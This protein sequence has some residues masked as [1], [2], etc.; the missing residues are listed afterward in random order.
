MGKLITDLMINNKEVIMSY[1]FLS[2]LS[3]VILIIRRIKNKKDFMRLKKET[4]SFGFIKREYQPEEDK[5][6]LALWE[7]NQRLEQELSALKK[8]YNKL[9]IWVLIV[10]IFTLFFSKVNEITKKTKSIISK[11]NTQV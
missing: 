9:S 7:D 11:K 4:I 2:T 10:L 8:E 5:F 1:I 3:I 6:L